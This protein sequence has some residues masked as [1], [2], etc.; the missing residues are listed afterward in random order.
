MRF[1]NR[2]FIISGSETAAPAKQLV[3][4]NYYSEIEPKKIR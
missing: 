2:I 1:P 3:N 4:L